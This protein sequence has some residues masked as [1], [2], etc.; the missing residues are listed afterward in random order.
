MSRL[1]TGSSRSLRT[2]SKR[3]G[4]FASR[5]TRLTSTNTTRSLVLAGVLIQDKGR[6]VGV[7]ACF[8]D[9]CRVE[10][11]QFTDNYAYDRLAVG[12]EVLDPSELVVP[13]GIALSI[14]APILQRDQGVATTSI[15]GD[16][17]GTVHADSRRAVPIP[18]RL[19]NEQIGLEL[20]ER[21]AVDAAAIRLSASQPERDLATA[22]CAAVLQYLE[23]RGEL[24]FRPRA[25]QFVFTNC[26]DALF[27]DS[28]TVH[29]LELVERGDSE[30]GTDAD[31]SLQR[32]LRFTQTAEGARALRR[33]ILEPPANRTVIEERLD[34]L[35]FM[36]SNDAIYYELKEALRQ[37]P[38]V[39]RT[40]AQIFH[41]YPRARESLGMQAQ[42]HIRDA[43]VHGAQSTD[44][45]VD[46]RFV[47]SVWQLRRALD[48]LFRIR[49]A[50]DVF[51]E[52]R[53]TQTGTRT[54]PVLLEWCRN[55]ARLTAL[56]DLHHELGRCL[57]STTEVELELGSTERNRLHIA[58]ALRAG[59]NPL[60]DAARRALSDTVSSVH[61]LAEATKGQLRCPRLHVAYSTLRGYH[62]VLPLRDAV[63]QSL[64]RTEIGGVLLRYPVRSGKKLLFTTD[65]LIR[66]NMQYQETLAEI[67]HLSSKELSKLAEMA[68]ST[69]SAHAI[70]EFCDCVA[71][72]DVTLALA[73]CIRRARDRSSCPWVRPQFPDTNVMAM[74]DGR[75]LLLSHLYEAQRRDPPRPND[76]YIDDAH[77][78]MLLFGANASGKS[79]Y[80][81]Q[82]ALIVV[83]AQMGC[84]VP[85]AFASMPVYS[86]LLVRS[87]SDDA[88]E[89]NLSSFAMEMREIT[90]ALHY[91]DGEALSSALN[92]LDQERRIHKLVL[93]DEVGR[94]TGS[95]DGK[96]IA[97]AMLEYLSDTTAHIIFATHFSEL[98][99]TQTYLPNV[100]VMHLQ[101]RV[102]NG[103]LYHDY[104]LVE[105]APASSRYGAEVAAQAGL[106]S[107]VVTRALQF[108]GLF[109]GDASTS[110]TTP[111]ATDTGNQGFLSI[112]DETWAHCRW[113]TK[114]N[115]LLQRLVMLSYVATSPEDQC[116]GVAELASVFADL[117]E[118]PAAVTR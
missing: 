11:R 35:D 60:L 56:T 24:S 88:L 36:L 99:R 87:R 91:I 83:L 18:R 53:S 27:M 84:F 110:T 96:S 38:S 22:A 98:A 29:C 4:T 116:A 109:S 6:R 2:L 59:A 81:R 48:S 72:L 79:V 7:A 34:A 33:A 3:S 69:A 112:D 42:S 93:F 97:W 86:V 68:T 37:T 9:A 28:C 55:V 78:V 115:T 51:L 113:Y 57:A 19:F 103:T 15:S 77:N 41:I 74:K 32:T 89:H 108:R 23:H 49:E 14:L 101:S 44:H 50:L 92:P 10:L 106:P 16:G 70:H 20:M 54:L 66:L 90:S 85:A 8:V 80:M 95:L 107:A 1:V 25:V 76:V 111:T 43:R 31:I 75:H 30:S 63:Q 61:R 17:S 100:H 65:A 46:F 118:T 39:E 21:F 64:T 5:S 105:G 82:T 117:F 62:F 73:T 102:E 52:E 114:A 40:I 45:V 94:S 104:K 58:F 67:W 47:R 12:L 71:A 13:D 26:E